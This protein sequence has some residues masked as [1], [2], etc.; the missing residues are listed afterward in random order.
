MGPCSAKSTAVKT[1]SR[2]VSTCLNLFQQI[3]LVS[4][5]STCP[6][7]FPDISCQTDV[8]LLGWAPQ[9]SAR[10]SHVFAHGQLTFETL[11]QFVQSSYLPLAE[12]DFTWV[13]G[14]KFRVA[15]AMT[16]G[17][18]ISAHPK[19]R[20][21]HGAPSHAPSSSCSRTPTG[22][23]W[24]LSQSVTVRVVMM[25]HHFDTCSHLFQFVKAYMTYMSV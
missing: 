14:L 6:R 5:D 1:D 13:L 23:G 24:I 7:F 22:Y 17:E 20:K 25:K 15:P 16:L 11:L 21:R 12:V 18:L 10:C 4:T 2:S 9:A 19:I 8:S 3:Q